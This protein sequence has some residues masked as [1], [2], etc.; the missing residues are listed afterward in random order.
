MFRSIFK[1]RGV[2]FRLV[3][4]AGVGAMVSLLGGCVSQDFSDLEAYTQDVLARPGGRIEPIPEI[5]PYEAYA[6][7]AAQKGERD[8]F[9]LF[10]QKDEAK[11]AD[12]DA[13]LTPEMERELRYRNREELEQFE[14]DSLRMVGT[15]ED[16]GQTWAIIRDPGGIVHRVREGNYLGRNVGKI[17]NI[18]EDR[19]EL[20][21]IY[22]DGQGRWQERAASI[23]LAE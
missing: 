23:A 17:T 22:Q 19:V 14:L 6:Y 5:K 12:T 10:Y 1:T 16:P 9:R 8:P 18:Y 13:G 3:W 15:L 21:E 7:Q 2:A 11:L 4:L 20:R